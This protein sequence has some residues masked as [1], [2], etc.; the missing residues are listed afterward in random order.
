MNFFGQ[1]LKL[2]FTALSYSIDVLMRTMSGMQK[3]AEEGID[4]MVGG[5]AGTLENGVGWGNKDYG[6]HTGWNANVT[7]HSSP[8]E[9]KEMWDKDSWE[10]DLKV[11]RYWVL[12]DKRDYEEVFS[13]SEIEPDLHRKGDV[14]LVLGRKSLEEFRGEK[15][16]K[17]RERLGTIPRPK[18]WRDLQYPQDE[19]GDFIGKLDGNDFDDYVSVIVEVVHQQAR[20]DRDYERDKVQLL[21]GINRSINRVGDDISSKIG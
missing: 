21:G 7:D 10:S 19:K 15:R 4:R 9:A 2:P 18:K 11:V 14:E 17:F 6:S 5:A 12:F 3:V 16:T 13:S 8:K 20:R 1:L